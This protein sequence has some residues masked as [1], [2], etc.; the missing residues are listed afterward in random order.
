MSGALGLMF[1]F[2]KF[3]TSSREFDFMPS[4]NL[5]VATS[6][7]KISIFVSVINL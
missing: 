3:G 5:V 1:L 6:I 4:V 7:V 2:E